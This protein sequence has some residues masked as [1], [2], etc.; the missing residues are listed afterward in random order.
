[1]NDENGF[2]SLTRFYG[3]VIIDLTR[4]YGQ[5]RAGTKQM[6]KFIQLNKRTGETKSHMNQARKQGR[7]PAVLYGIG[8]DT[9]SFE[10]NEKEMLNILKKNPRAILQGKTSDEKVIPVIVQNIQRDNHVWQIAAYRLSS[11]EYDG[12]HG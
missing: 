9:L 8:K 1:M 10:V 12:K 7:I 2:S 4:I 5:K 11:C 6:S 3:H